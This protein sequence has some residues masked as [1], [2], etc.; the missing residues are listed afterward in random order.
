MKPGSISAGFLVCCFLLISFVLPNQGIAAQAEIEIELSP[1]QLNKIA[2]TPMW[3]R[4]LAYRPQGK[5]SQII[6]TDFFLHPKGNVSPIEELKKNVELLSRPITRQ[7]AKKHIICTKPAR[8]HWLDQ[9]IAVDIQA[10]RRQFCRG[11]NDWIK[12]DDLESISVMMVS[13]YFGNPASTFG[14][15]LIKL[16]SNEQQG[17]IL[18]DKSINFGALIPPNENTLA[19]VLKGIFGFYQAGFSDRQYYL[20]DLIYSQTESRDIWEYK[21]VMDEQR[22][23]LAAYY[24]YE[25]AG[26][27]YVYYFFD[28]NC[29]YRVS[30]FLEVIFDTD[31]LHQYKPWYLPVESL[32]ALRELKAKHPEIQ[33]QGPNYIPSV[34]TEVLDLYSKLNQR[35]KK[36][37]NNI[38]KQI[39]EM[40]IK[41]PNV[42]ID[43]E[44][45]TTSL[46]FLI[47]Y[48]TYKFRQGNGEYLPHHNHVRNEILAKRLALP[49]ENRNKQDTIK[50][51]EA[52]SSGAKPQKM[53]MFFNK[54]K[55]ENDFYGFNFS[56]ASFESI[57]FNKGQLADSDLVAFDI[58]LGVTK[59]D[60]VFLQDFDLIRI[61]N[62]NSN[63]TTLVNEDNQSWMINSGITRRS[64]DCYNCH[65]AYLEGALGY[66]KK[67]Q[68]T[69]F[70][71]MVGGYYASAGS[72]IGAGP[73]LG[74][75]YQPKFDRMKFSIK[76]QYDALPPFSEQ[77]N[78]V[79][80]TSRYMLTKDLHLQ[81][82]VDMNT[83][84][85]YQLLLNKYF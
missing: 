16:N 41:N 32:H 45:N 82:A 81:F 73:Y 56:A 59:N 50:E 51:I 80:L 14:H 33:V 21:L 15:A 40:D 36:Q 52:P 6:S 3:R 13:G 31:I 27:K 55:V 63:T 47:K 79:K 85:R 8:T 5:V 44:I 30:E 78:V 66:S 38:I 74:L 39:Q 11:L 46:N 84:S 57:G 35:Q 29:A 28:K 37:V 68:N 70:Y 61:K 34:Q 42:I 18:E 19:Y 7:N 76:Y 23:L 65:T 43:S 48:M 64:Y 2:K 9:Y 67:I 71:A 1:A 53:A 4:L 20:Q 25:L 26:K 75:E 49:A 10:L 54:A 83:D 17:T 58:S 62:I 12:H 60:A 72:E 24:L 77:K 69:V 22:L